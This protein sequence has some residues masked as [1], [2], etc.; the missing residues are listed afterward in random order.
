MD[1]CRMHKHNISYLLFSVCLCVCVG[2]SI[3]VCHILFMLQFVS[4]SHSTLELVFVANSPKI[5]LDFFIKHGEWELKDT[6]LTIKELV[7]A[8]WKGSTIEVYSAGWQFTV[9]IKNYTPQNL[10]AG[11]K[12]LFTNILRSSLIFSF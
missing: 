10:V 6:N 7:A 8:G 4:M 2:G 1:A 5:L 12:P 11:I 3:I 9:G